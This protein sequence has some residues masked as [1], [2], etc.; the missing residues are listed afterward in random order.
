MSDLR[1]QGYQA[2]FSGLRQRST[3]A[4]SSADALWDIRDVLSAVFYRE[5]NPLGDDQYGMELEKNQYK[6]EEGVFAA[7]DGYIRAV[8]TVQD[9]LWGNA[10]NY[11]DAEG[12][13]DPGG[14][15]PGSPSPGGQGLPDP[16]PDGRL[17]PPADASPAGVPPQG[18]GPPLPSLPGM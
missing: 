11:E 9:G 14:E 8:E 16:P 18:D 12:Y 3:Q 5:G 2:V 6:I 15:D 4:G 7:F 13:G 10:R 1:G 17:P